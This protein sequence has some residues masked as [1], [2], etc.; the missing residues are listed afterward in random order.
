MVDDLTVAER[1]VRVMNDDAE[2][3]K[4]KGREKWLSQRMR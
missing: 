1:I 2:E 3:L 4:A